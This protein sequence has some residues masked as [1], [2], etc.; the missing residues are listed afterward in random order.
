MQQII[1]ETPIIASFR[2]FPVSHRPEERDSDVAEGEYFDSG[3]GYAFKKLHNW[4]KAQ[5]GDL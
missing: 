3:K 4:V 5:C 1:P 2:E